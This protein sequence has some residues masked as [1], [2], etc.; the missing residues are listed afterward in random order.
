MTATA[1]V[2]VPWQP[3]ICAPP[4]DFQVVDAQTIGRL[5]WRRPE[6]SALGRA[7]GESLES[8]G[9]MYRCGRLRW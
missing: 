3:W 2:L 8:N 1:T 6:R 4:P 9:A 5:G 7:G